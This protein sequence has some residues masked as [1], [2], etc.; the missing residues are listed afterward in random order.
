MH[1]RERATVIL[2]QHILLPI[3]KISI[4]IIISIQCTKRALK[5]LVNQATSHSFVPPT[6][7]VIDDDF[8]QRMER[9]MLQAL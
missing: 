4:S 1:I 9:D 7:K 8:A 2:L 3:I 5:V 6:E